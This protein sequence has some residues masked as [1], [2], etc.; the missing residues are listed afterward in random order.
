MDNTYSMTNE[1]VKKMWLDIKDIIIIFFYEYFDLDMYEY[2]CYDESVYPG[3][4]S[5]VCQHEC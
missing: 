3:T 4:E 1:K 2:Y 5:C